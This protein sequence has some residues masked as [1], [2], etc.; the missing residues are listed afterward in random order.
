[1]AN[2]KGM[3]GMLM[4]YTHSRPVK[5]ESKSTSSEI[6]VRI[7]QKCLQQYIRIV[8]YTAIIAVYNPPEQ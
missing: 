5:Q 1:M 6:G 8:I 3:E 7:L 4:H 2:V